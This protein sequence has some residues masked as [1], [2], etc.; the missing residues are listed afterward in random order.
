MW[1]GRHGV[2]VN[3]HPVPYLRSSRHEAARAGRL[4]TAAAGPS[5]AGVPYR[6][7]D[8]ER[9]DQADARRS[10]GPGRTNIPGVVKRAPRAWL[11]HQV[12]AIYAAA[13][14]STTWQPAH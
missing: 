10:R 7:P 9:H 1:V 8:P 6:H 11:G 2:R 14:R 5:R 12:T 3:G 13:R 4:L